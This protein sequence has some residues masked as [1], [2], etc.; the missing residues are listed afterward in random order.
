MLRRRLPHVPLADV[1]RFVPGL[2][3]AFGE[4]RH[5][6]RDARILLLRRRILLVDVHWQPATQEGGARWRAKLEGVVLLEGEP[7]GTERVHVRREDLRVVPAHVAPAHIIAQRE[8]QVRLHR[9]TANMR[10]FA[11]RKKNH[12][13]SRGLYREVQKREKRQGFFDTVCRS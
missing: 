13:P 6:E 10:R 5:A 11:A 3:E 4:Q 12:T 2:S 7:S 9:A 8:D 1:R